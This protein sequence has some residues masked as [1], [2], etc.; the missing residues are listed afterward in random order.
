M[1]GLQLAELLGVIRRQLWVSPK[2]HDLVRLK[3]QC[4]QLRADVDPVAIDSSLAGRV[5]PLNFDQGE[6]IVPVLQRCC[7]GWRHLF[8][9]WDLVFEPAQVDPAVFALLEPCFLFFLQSQ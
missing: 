5:E 3:L 4:V 2:V 7:V 1:P 8:Q 6:C 9:S